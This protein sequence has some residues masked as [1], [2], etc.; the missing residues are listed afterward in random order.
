MLY[1]AS[2]VTAAPAAMLAKRARKSREVRR[3]GRRRRG[4]FRFLPTRR[5]RRLRRRAAGGPPSAPFRTAPP[6]APAPFEP[7]RDRTVPARTLRG[8]GLSG[9][10]VGTVLMK[11]RSGGAGRG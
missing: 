5:A 4:A 11:L 1:P 2:T 8:R 6:P 9:G 3:S 7:L 10:V